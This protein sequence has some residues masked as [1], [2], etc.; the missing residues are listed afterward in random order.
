MIIVGD[1][2]IEN[3]NASVTCCDG[4]NPL[5]GLASCGSRATVCAVLLENR[6]EYRYVE[7]GVTRRQ[8]PSNIPYPDG[9]LSEKVVLTLDELRANRGAIMPSIACGPALRL[10]P[11]FA[12]TS[13]AIWYPRKQNVREGFDTTIAFQISQ[14]SFRCNIMDDVNTYCRSRGILFLYNHLVIPSSNYK[15]VMN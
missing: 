10:T 9:G 14:P 13:G 2:H 11:S 3:C 5:I 12:R 15:I 8:V 6:L 4:Y 1:A 7:D